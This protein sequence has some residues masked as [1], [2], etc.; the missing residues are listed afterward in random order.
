MSVLE[1]GK[2]LPF[3]IANTVFLFLLP[4]NINFEMDF[5]ETN[6]HWRSLYMVS[7][8]RMTSHGKKE[9]SSVLQ[10]ALSVLRCA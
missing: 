6:T 5:R 10:T 8:H 7:I 9:M 1:T 3:W 4:A 2:L